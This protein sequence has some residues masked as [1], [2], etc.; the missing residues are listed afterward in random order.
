MSDLIEEIAAAYQVPI[1]MLRGP[2]EP[3]TPEQA[4]DLRKFHVLH[5]ARLKGWKRRT[6][7]LQALMSKMARKGIKR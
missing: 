4:R 7:R 3:S 5:N 6:R 1:D 2:R